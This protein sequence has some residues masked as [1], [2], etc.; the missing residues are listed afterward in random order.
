MPNTFYYSD[1][2]LMKGLKLAVTVVASLLPIISIVVLC[3]I[4]GMKKRLGMI[5]LFTTMF[6]MSLGVMTGGK[7]IEIF[8]ATAA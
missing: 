1:A 4:D 7:P 2:K 6:S 5:G 3:S 8:A